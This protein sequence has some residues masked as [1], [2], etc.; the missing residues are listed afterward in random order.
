MYLE[1]EKLKKKKSRQ[2][3]KRKTKKPIWGH[4]IPV[5]TNLPCS[6]LNVSLC[7]WISV[8]ELILSQHDKRIQYNEMA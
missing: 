8:A 7:H 2:R 5:Y 4:F 6:L 3:A 1:D